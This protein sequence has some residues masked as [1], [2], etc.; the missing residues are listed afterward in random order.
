MSSDVAKL[1]LDINS[2]NKG[3]GLSNI[4]TPIEIVVLA[5]KRKILLIST[6]L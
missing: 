1:V 2:H 5:V 4:D 6:F 3:L